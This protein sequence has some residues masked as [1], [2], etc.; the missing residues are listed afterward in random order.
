MKNYV[1]C[2]KEPRLQILPIQEVQRKPVGKPFLLTCRPDVPD[3]NLI[4]DLQWRDNSNMR[5]MPKTPTKYTPMYNSM[6]QKILMESGQSTPPM[7]TEVLPGDQSLALMITSLTEGMAGIYYCSASYANNVPLEISVRIETYVAITWV[8]AAESQFPKAGKTSTIFCEVTANPA[9]T[10][11]WL[12]NGD[13]VNMQLMHVVLLIRDIDQNDDGIYTCRAAV[14]QTGELVERNIRVEVHIPPVIMSLPKVLEAVEEQQFSVQCNATGKPVPEYTWIKDHSQV[15]VETADRFL[16]NK[17]T[18]QMSITRV[19]HED[20]GTYT[21]IAK[22]NAG[23]DEAT[24]LINVL[25]RPRVYE[26]LNITIAENKE[27]A[28]ICKATGRPAPEITFRR[29][30]SEEEFVTGPQPDDDRIVLEQTANDERGE[31]TGTLRIYKMMR[32]DDGL[33]ECVARNRG[34]QAFK[35][36]HITV[37]YK[38]NFDHM[39]GLPPVF[40]WE[41]RRANLSCL[42]Q[43]FPNATI[44]WRWNDRAIKDLGDPNLQIESHGPRSDLLVIPRDRRY[45]SAYKCIASNRLGVAT[46]EMILREARLPGIVQSATPR[47]VTA[48]TMTFDIIGPATELGLPI[49]TYSVQYKEFNQQDWA[50]ALNKTW[51]AANEKTIDSVYTIEGLKPATA[52]TFQFAARNLVGLGPWSAFKQQSTPVRSVPEPPKI[53]HATDKNTDSNDEEQIVV[54]PYSDHFDLSWQLSADNGEPINYYQV[55]YCPG[56]KVDGAWNEIAQLCVTQDV[57]KTVTNDFKMSGLSGDTYYRIE[58]RAH[59]A[60]GFSQPS[61]LLMRTARGSDL[62]IRVDTPAF[63]SAAI[64]GIAIGGVLLLIILIDFLCCLIMNTGIMASL[65]RRTKRSP[66]EL[67]DESKIGS[68][69]GWRFPLPYCSGQL[70][71]EPPPSPLPLPPPVKLGGSPLTTPLEEKEPLNTPCGS[72]KNS[73]VEYDGRVVHSR[74]GEIIGKNSSV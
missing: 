42:A 5:V 20:Y 54:S 56:L 21:C 3:A 58:V 53:L 9:P 8:N 1:R 26:L 73:I 35:V 11:D 52:Y 15:N 46:H 19:T 61:P 50:F 31:A 6:G 72:M 30:G 16:V 29:W 17:I 70:V 47:I 14:I 67:D 37:E 62:V 48:T 23:Q 71:K 64:I 34:Q 43:G 66:S 74:S 4:T 49:L 25:I 22:N 24:T 40:S 57:P 27:G 32:S 33:Y 13:P 55:R 69:Y 60:I 45:Y 63:S 41:E 28:L 7:Y 65:C 68:L 36:G 12:R 39:K 10:V 38:P 18:G 59:N 2:Q 51:T 44:E